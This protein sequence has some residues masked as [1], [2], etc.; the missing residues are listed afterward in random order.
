MSVDSRPESGPVLGTR[1][2]SR[3]LIAFAG[4]PLYPPFTIDGKAEAQGEEVT[5]PES[6]AW[7]SGGDT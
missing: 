6:G 5:S 7:G 3:A 1:H 2:A 4:S